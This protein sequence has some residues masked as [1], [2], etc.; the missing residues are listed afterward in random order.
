MGRRRNGWRSARGKR[1]RD[2]RD[3]RSG[4]EGRDRGNGKVVEDLS[5]GVWSRDGRREG[6]GGRR[7]GG[8]SAGRWRELD[9]TA[10]RTRDRFAGTTAAVASAVGELITDLSGVDDLEEKSNK[11]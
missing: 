10:R 8:S 6:A 5:R 1:T 3:R 11:R 7:G 4:E 9:A 2:G